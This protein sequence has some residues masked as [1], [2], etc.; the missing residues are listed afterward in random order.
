MTHE[1]AL[2]QKR[3]L[4]KQVVARRKEL[5]RSFRTKASAIV[6]ARFYEEK[7]F[8]AANTIFAYASMPEEVQLDALLQK[9]LACRKRVALPLITGKGIMEAVELPS[10]DSLVVG[11][12][13]IRTVDPLRQHAVPASEIDCIVIPGA[14]FTEKGDRLGLGGGYYDRYMAEKAP[15]AKR[16]ALTFDC[17]VIP[18]IPM[19]WHDQ[20][21]ETILT[22]KRR[23]HVARK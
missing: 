12:F 1:E 18:A 6:C 21:V 7:A 8:Q 19:E 22:E 9:C 3:V 13:G 5:S 2:L 11:A 17:L 15:Q 16:I 23:I 10:L 14:A 20:R 4:R